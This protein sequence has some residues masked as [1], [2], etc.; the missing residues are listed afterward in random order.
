MEGGCIG[1]SLFFRRKTK[2]K[3]IRHKSLP[4]SISFETQKR[5]VSRVLWNRVQKEAPRCA[6][7]PGAFTLEA[8]IVLPL[9]ASFFVSLLFFFR[10]MQVQI[11][12]QKAL[13]DTGRKLAVY[14][15]EE[16]NA[17]ERQAEEGAEKGAQTKGLAEHAAAKTIFFKEVLKWEEVQ[18]YVKGGAPGIS[19]ADSEFFQDEIALKAVYRIRLPVRLFW[20]WDI[21][22]IQRAEC[23]KWTGWNGMGTAGADDVWV[24]VTETGTV[25][26]KTK[27]CTHLKLSIQSISGE[28]VELLRNEKGE[29]YR[30]CMICAGKR[31]HFGKVYI[32]NQG[33]CYHNDLN[34]S[35]IKRTIS[36]IRISEVGNKSACLKCGGR[37]EAEG[38]C[39]I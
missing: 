36:M 39:G 32:T 12:V 19:L 35:G 1:V 6:R 28:A 34:C 27:N 4:E 30:E 7:M 22:M 13:D 16:G 21:R 2:N 18:K 3:R 31:N 38:A 14:L 33:D 10:V 15:S 5:S 17:D 37:V 20:D 26:H 25:Y 24:Y 29:K 9:M 23:R 11:E 8:A